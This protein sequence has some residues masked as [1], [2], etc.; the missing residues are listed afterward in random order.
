MCALCC[1][2]IVRGLR[3][4]AK[5]V[6][7]FACAS[8]KHTRAGGRGHTHTHIHTHILPGSPNK[9]LLV[10]PAHKLE[11]DTRHNPGCLPAPPPSLPH[12]HNPDPTHQRAAGATQP[13]PQPASSA[14][15]QP[16]RPT[17]PVSAD[18]V[19]PAPARG[20]L[21]HQRQIHQ[22]Q[23]QRPV[24]ADRARPASLRG[25][26]DWQQPWQQQQQQLL[27]EHAARRPLSAQQQQQQLLQEHVARRPL[28]AQPRGR[29]SSTT[30]VA[31]PS[32][33]GTAACLLLDH[34]AG[35][36]RMKK[37]NASHEAARIKERTVCSRDVAMC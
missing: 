28:S 34:A 2:V 18:R 16:T 11:I 14:L 15:A 22:Q 12:Q 29:H 19:R 30:G 31:P 32:T 23:P 8:Y 10:S 13:K 26:Q 5:W 6:H 24:S 35:E 17:R 25:A 21:Q 1:G 33:L 7:P 37:D 3:V 20:V 4:F 36:E 27:Q 9:P